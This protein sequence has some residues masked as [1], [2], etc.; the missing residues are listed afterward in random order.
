MN[1]A[2]GLMFLLVEGSSGNEKNISCVFENR[3]YAGR[4]IDQGIT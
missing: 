1:E 4:L 3:G 2:L